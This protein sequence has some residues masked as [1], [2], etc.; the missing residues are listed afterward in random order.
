MR[1]RRLSKELLSSPT[2]RGRLGR[3]EE[4]RAREGLPSVMAMGA[5]AYDN[6]PPPLT[7]DDDGRD[8]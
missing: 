4:R 8:A 3:S 7:D 1:D 5:E 6:R 2:S